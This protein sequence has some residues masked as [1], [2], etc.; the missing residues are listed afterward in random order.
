[1]I[2]E[3]LRTSSIR[4]ATKETD[5]TL[6]PPLALTGLTILTSER[7]FGNCVASRTDRLQEAAL[8][9]RDTFHADA[10]AE[11]KNEVVAE[12]KLEVDGFD[13]SAELSCMYRKDGRWFM[14][15]TTR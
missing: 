6:A 9:A 13:V 4:R 7:I 12:Y 8:G 2:P 10:L 11:Y 15:Y 3:T 1:M 14:E 5:I